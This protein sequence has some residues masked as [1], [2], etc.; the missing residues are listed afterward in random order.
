MLPGILQRFRE[1]AAR[2]S[3]RATSAASNRPTRLRPSASI[4][5]GFAGHGLTIHDRTR[6]ILGARQ[7]ARVQRQCRDSDGNCHAGRDQCIQ[8]KTR[9]PRLVGQTRFPRSPIPRFLNIRAHRA[10]PLVFRKG[11]RSLWGPF[12]DDPM[13]AMPATARTRT[14]ALR[15]DA[16]FIIMQQDF[17]GDGWPCRQFWNQPDGRNF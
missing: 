4:G 2:T 7:A 9:R 12:R 3:R 14:D 10:P 17:L 16:A 11:T 15:I 6:R 8:A 13:T 5:S 1:G